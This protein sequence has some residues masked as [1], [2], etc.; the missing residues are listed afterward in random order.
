M[1]RV[2][3]TIPDDLSAK[4]E[5]YRDNLETVLRVGLREMKLEQALGIY[6]QGQ[7]SLAKAARL[8]DVSL[9][10]MMSYAGAQGLKPQI[11]EDSIREDLA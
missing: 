11:D 7:I 6:K 3:L 1:S 10:E 4:L 8:A 2:V 5:P 9:R